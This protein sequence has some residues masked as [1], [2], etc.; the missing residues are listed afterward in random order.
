MKHE[1]TRFSAMFCVLLAVGGTCILGCST[2]S[3]IQPDNQEVIVRRNQTLWSEVARILDSQ[4]K[5]KNDTEVSVYLRNLSQS[6]LD[7]HL[8][9]KGAPI[10]VWLI[11][12][13]SGKWISLNLPGNRIYLSVELLK[14]LQFENE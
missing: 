3:P 12:P 10:G 4:I 5:Y 6:L 2:S 8:G 1:Y 14:Q 13:H 9:K 7:S 11:Y